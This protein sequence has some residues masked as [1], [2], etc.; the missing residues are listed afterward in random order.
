MQSPFGKNKY[1]NN[2]DKNGHTVSR[3]NVQDAR[4]DIIEWLGNLEYKK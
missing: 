3:N 1:L 2:R 4:P